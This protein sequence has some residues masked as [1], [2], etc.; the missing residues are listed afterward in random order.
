MSNLFQEANDLSIKSFGRRVKWQ[1]QDTYAPRPAVVSDGHQYDRRNPTGYLKVS[2]RRNPHRREADVLIENAS[3]GDDY[4]ITVQGTTYTYTAQGGDTASDIATGLAGKVDGNS[5][6]SA[7]ADGDQVLV[8][9]DIEA[10]YS[11]SLSST[12]S[13]SLSFD[14]LDSTTYS[15]ILVWLYSQTSQGDEDA[16]SWSIVNNLSLYD[17]VAREE[18]GHIAG[19]QSI[20]VQVTG[21]DEDVFVATGIGI[22]DEGQSN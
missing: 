17:D 20:Y 3:A 9:G 14:W 16:E 11:I 13:A 7:T 2:L 5:D 19:H 8:R 4:S 22:D 6:V 21:A 12:G 18:I 1:I 15:D 10:N